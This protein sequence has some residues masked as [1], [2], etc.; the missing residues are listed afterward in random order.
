MSAVKGVVMEVGR[1]ACARVSREVYHAKCKAVG[2]VLHEEAESSGGRGV[3]VVECYGAVVDTEIPIFSV[4][5][6][7]HDGRI[8]DG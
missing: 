5:V 3:E 4:A 6:L 2:L 8:G 1:P 7:R